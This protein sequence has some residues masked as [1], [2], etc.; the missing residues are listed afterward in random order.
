VTSIPAGVWTF[1]LKALVD[2][3]ADLTYIK[4]YAFS[5]NLAGTETALFN[6]TSAEINNTSVGAVTFSSTAQAAFTVAVT[7]RIVIKLY[8]LSTS[9]T[10]KTVTLYY[11]GAANYSIVLIPD[12]IPVREGDMTKAV[13]DTDG[14]GVL[15]ADAADLGSGSATN[16]Y[17]LTADGAGGA[18]WAAAAGG[19]VAT[20]TIW[21]AKGDLAVGTGA[22]TAA[23]LAV[24]AN[25]TVLMAASGEATGLKWDTVSGT[26]DVV[27]PA[28]STDNTI[29]RFNGT[30][31][32]T[33]QGSLST[34]DD[35]GGIN[36]PTGQTYNINGTPHAHDGGADANGVLAVSYG[37][38]PT[39]P[40]SGKALLYADYVP[41]G[42]SVVP[43]MTTNTYPSGTASASEA[44]SATP[45]YCA[46]N[47]TT[48]GW[49]T[50]GTA[51][52]Q[53]VRY[54]FQATI[55]V[56]GY[57][58]RPWWVDNYPAR[59]PK[60]W[61]MQGSA[62][63]SS[64]TTLDTQTNYSFANSTDYAVFTFSN[65]TAYLYYRLYITANNGDAYCGVG[66]WRMFQASTTVGLY[67]MDSDGSKKF[68]G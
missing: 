46:F 3:A 44:Y 25:G 9:G 52:P 11:Q 32:K 26:G 49:L 14:D 66:G 67:V 50:N 64:W 56:A 55:C 47:P 43:L 17:V 35:S 20:A 23:R 10:D 27:G 63:A 41:A 62:D 38:P 1:S 59:T 54:Q 36:I 18:A 19:D 58:I 68:I 29:T 53:W 22:D 7:D 57:S 30:D 6:A 16:T 12:D 61:T 8:A 24:G 37:T 31:N 39:S 51:L 42:P 28:T 15:V 45:A 65:T 48:N 34:V 40:V 2:S 4:A 21:D 5:R 60:T 13:Y 33:I